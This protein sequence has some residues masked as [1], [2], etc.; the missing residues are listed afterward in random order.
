MNKDDITA[1]LS[2]ALDAL[3]LK[4]KVA[5]AMG[6]C[7][8]FFLESFARALSPL[9]SAVVK[10]ILEPFGYVSCIAGSVFVLNIP[11]LRKS[12]NPIKEVDQAIALVEKYRQK[13]I[14]SDVEAKMEFRKLVTIATQRLILAKDEEKKQS[15]DVVTK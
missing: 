11:T 5:T 10:E 7:L 2:R 12:Y 4:N 6:I 14:Y 13:G 9:A 3:F 8:G 15:E 1:C